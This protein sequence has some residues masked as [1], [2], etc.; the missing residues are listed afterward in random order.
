MASCWLS[1]SLLLLV[2]SLF[3]LTTMNPVK[4][5]MH[6]KEVCGELLAEALKKTCVSY[7]GPFSVDLRP[8]NT[9]AHATRR[10]V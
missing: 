3:T 5:H 10:F 7:R 4:R 8:G 6:H 1:Q 2:V 9:H